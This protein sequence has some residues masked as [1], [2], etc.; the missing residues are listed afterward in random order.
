MFLGEFEHT[1][2]EKGRITIPA[3]FRGRLAAGMVITKA[4]DN[5]LWLYPMDVWE[6]LAQRI[7]NLRLT[8]P[9]AREFSRQ[10]FGSASDA[11]P[12]R[13]GRVNLPTYLRDYAGIDKQAVVIGLYNHCEVWNADHWRER[14]AQS[15]ED[16]EGRAALFE[17]LGI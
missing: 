6:D 9:K 3:K 12:D 14:Q 8:D 11:V 5:C 13:Q 10:V 1:I 4:I 15:H 2:D 16:P 7:S 17:S